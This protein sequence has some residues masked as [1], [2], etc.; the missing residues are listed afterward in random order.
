MSESRVLATTGELLS[1]IASGTAVTRAALAKETGLAP[2]TVTQRVGALVDQG[3]LLEDVVE[4]T[5]GR[6]AKHLAFAPKVGVLLTADL[7]V[8]RA[9]LAVTDLGGASLDHHEG[10]I[11]IGD[12]PGPILTW[13]DAQFRAMLGDLGLSPVDVL[14]VACG[15]PGPVD[16]AAGRVVRPP[17]MPG[18]EGYGIAS[19]L[20]SRYEVPVEVD[21]DVNLMAIG[22][23][24][25]RRNV[26]HML[27]VKIGTGIGCG[28]IS[29]G[30][31]H[32]GANGAAGDI[33]HVLVPGSEAPCN[34]GYLGCLEA[35]A[36]GGA[37]A[38]A[39]R[40][41]GMDVPTARR[42]AAL[43]AEGNGKARRAIQAAAEQIGGVLAAVVNFHNPSLIVLGGALTAFQETLVAG[44]R[45]QIFGRALALGTSSL[46]IEISKEE[47]NAGT[48]G[49]AHLARKAALSPPG[50]ARLLARRSG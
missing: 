2:S 20:R 22:A 25:T 40:S 9:R 24:L 29:G 15:V 48:A 33:G 18:W 4:R 31:L 36:S 49:A 8:T 42:V 39:L 11:T 41:E 35:V 5:R 32:R 23:H 50:L 28:V 19:F 12:G 34:C 46:S 10:D 7:G 43:A 3:I 21:N 26:E 45:G 38:A 37:L 27:F 13:V 1:R 17:V 44:I 14:A 16:Y 6:P 47:D 30:Q